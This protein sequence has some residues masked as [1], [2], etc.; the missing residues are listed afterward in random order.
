M[1]DFLSKPQKQSNIDS[2]DLEK[3]YFEVHLDHFGGGQELERYV[4]IS[5]S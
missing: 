2:L 1:H 3:V 4:Q 5:C